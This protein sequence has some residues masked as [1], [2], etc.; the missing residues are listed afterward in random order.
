MFI[1][2]GPSIYLNGVWVGAPIS[3]SSGLNA[4]G[5]PYVDWSKLMIFPKNHKMIFTI[6]GI[7]S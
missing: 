2:N 4:V 7:I 3:D 5:P 6:Y 1:C